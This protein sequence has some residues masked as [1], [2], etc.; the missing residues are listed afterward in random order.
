MSFLVEAITEY[1]MDVFTSSSILRLISDSDDRT[2]LR[3]GQE[4]YRIMTNSLFRFDYVHPGIGN[5]VHIV[6]YLDVPN[7]SVLLSMAFLRGANMNYVNEYGDSPVHTYLKRS[8][9]I[10]VNILSVTLLWGINLD[11]VPSGDGVTFDKL[12]ERAG[13]LKTDVVV[14]RDS[15]VLTPKASTMKRK[16]MGGPIR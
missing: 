2:P 3:T 8:R 16:R 13:L 10:D 12:C 5:I 1:M 7:K 4:L 14:I 15:G 9:N 11:L 6:F